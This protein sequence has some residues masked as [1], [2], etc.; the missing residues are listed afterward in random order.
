MR[1]YFAPLEGVTDTVYRRTH[2]ECFGGVEKYFIPFISPTQHLAL[3]SREQRAVS[4]A[5]NAGVPVVP[6][7]LT[8]E[9]AHFVAMANNLADLG[10][11]EVN[12]NLGCPSGT[13]TAKGKG[14]GMLRDPEGLRRFLDELYAHVRVKVS[15]KTRIGFASVDEWPRLAS[16]FPEY[17]VSELIVHPRTRAEFYR[18]QPHPQ[19]L[20]ALNGAPFDVVYNGDLNLPADCFTFSDRCPGV[21]ALMIGRGLVANPALAQE[22]CGGLALT[23][24][25]LRAFAELLLK[26]YLECW[27]ANAVIGHMHEILRYMLCCFEDPMPIRRLLR[28]AK[29]VDQL[30]QAMDRLFETY[31]LRAEPGFSMDQL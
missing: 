22:V 3:T 13:V 8:K 7:I 12:L 14:A 17:P 19:L 11:K 28:K 24:E 10:Y 16:I 2:R 9:A 25:A 6:Q 30:R 5:E 1:I 4:P 27:P 20:E 29:T 26:R 18:G 21:S 31:T 15:I 23:V